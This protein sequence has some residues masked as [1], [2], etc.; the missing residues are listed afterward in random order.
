MQ[1]F[2]L[3]VYK[4]GELQGAAQIHR[5]VI[6]SQLWHSVL[7]LVLGGYLSTL[8]NVFY[9]AQV[10]QGVLLKLPGTDEKRLLL[11]ESLFICSLLSAELQ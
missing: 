6:I 10:A 2:T 11:E 3:P 1:S 8:L 5:A 4:S 7:L 9:K